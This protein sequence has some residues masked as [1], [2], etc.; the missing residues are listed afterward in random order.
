MKKIKKIF[1]LLIAMVM[2][3]GMSTMAFASD[4]DAPAA[5]TTGS[6]T[7]TNAAANEK[8]AVYKLF[9]ATVVDKDHIAYTVPEGKT[10]P[11]D[12]TWFEVDTAGNVS[13]KEDA[14]IT[15][16]DFAKWAKSF[17][18]IQGSEVTATSSVVKFENLPF[19]YYFVTSSLG[20]VLTVDSTTPDVEVIDKNKSNPTPPDEGKLKTADDD[21]AAI[22]ETVNYTVAWNAVNWETKNKETKAV[23]FYGVKDESTALKI[24][25]T[26]IV[27]KVGETPLT[28]D[29]Y[30]INKK[31]GDTTYLVYIP[32][33]TKVDNEVGG[34]KFKFN[35]PVDVTITYPAEITKEA[36]DKATNKA[37]VVWD[38]GNI[39]S[40]E[41]TVETYSFDIVKDDNT[42]TVLTGAQFEL[43]ADDGTTKLNLVKVSDGVYRL[44]D[45]DE[46]ATEGFKSA[47]IEAGKATIQG[48]DGDKTYMLEE[49]VAPKGYNKLTD[50][51]S[52]KI[53]NA[54]NLAIVTDGKYVS[55]GV[56]VVNIAGTEL[57]S[58]GGMGTTIFYI[59]GAILVVGAGVV[60]VT[61]RRMN[62]N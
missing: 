2:V 15:T 41:V 40:E 9:S 53:N 51:K 57:P 18:T 46:A 42:K 23:T 6:I 24:D 47:V 8:Y 37:T 14:D 30:E 36:T 10:L 1:A 45:K 20:T 60:L 34:Y 49:T 56:E 33:S 19:G 44:A 55:G 35:A 54:D 26:N 25:T 50:K 4:V 11:A 58:T 7:V 17:G 52:V 12:N 29:Q 27:V 21:S 16:D 31:V 5:K 38:N 48:L 62:A 39:P 61:R 43:Y 13:L 28:A 3:L 22:G 32:W 59:I